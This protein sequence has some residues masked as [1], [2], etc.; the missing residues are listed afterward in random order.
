MAWPYTFSI[1]ITKKHL[2]YSYVKIG[3]YNNATGDIIRES[4]MSTRVYP[5]KTMSDRTWP[6]MIRT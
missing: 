2:Y 6:C 5:Y 1:C 4:E 3:Q